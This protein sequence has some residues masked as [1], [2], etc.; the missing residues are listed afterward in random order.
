MYILWKEKPQSLW[1]NREYSFIN[2]VQNIDYINLI[3][4]TISLIYL[5]TT[6]FS[7]L[8]SLT[9]TL[10]SP[11]VYKTDYVQNISF[12]ALIDFVFT[13]CFINIA[14]TYKHNI[15]TTL[16]LPIEL[17]LFD[18][19]SNNLIFKTVSLSIIFPSS[20]QIILN[21]YIILLDSS[22]SLVLRYKWLI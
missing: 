17:K 15:L 4:A 3:Y 10:T 2:S 1:L 6:A 18:R 13:Y 21:M 9:F 22:C 11:L 7:N 12:H 20:D 14:F 8:N 16:I 5:N 19:S